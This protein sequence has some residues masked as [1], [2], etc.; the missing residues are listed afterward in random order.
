MCFE[1]HYILNVILDVF[2]FSLI[3]IR[4]LIIFIQNLKENERVALELHI[5]FTENP[6]LV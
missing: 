1:I 6:R 2:L 3:S 5:L 4:S